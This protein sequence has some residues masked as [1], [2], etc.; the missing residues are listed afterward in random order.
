Q[1]G[2]PREFEDLVGLRLGALDFLHLLGRSSFRFLGRRRWLALQRNDFRDVEAR[3]LHD[4]L[5]MARAQPAHGLA[6]TA[7]GRGRNAGAARQPVAEYDI[8]ASSGAD[9]VGWQ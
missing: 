9:A 4:I 3:C 2:T 5:Q 1:F 7:E 6:E 8:I